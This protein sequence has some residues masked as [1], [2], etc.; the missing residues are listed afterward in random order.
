MEAIEKSKKMK[1]GYK[2]KRFCLRLRFIGWI[3]LCILTFGIGFLLMI[4][5]MHATF[6]KFYNDVKNN[7]IAK[8]G[9]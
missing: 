1:Y 8:I 3:L 6:A 2:W 5:Y 9:S 4:P 7:P